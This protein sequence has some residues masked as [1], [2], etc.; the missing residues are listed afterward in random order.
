MATFGIG[1]VARVPGGVVLGRLAD[2]RGR[3]VAMTR[4]IA[5]MGVGTAVVGL[6][7][8]YAVLG[9]YAPLLLLAG[10]LLQGFSAGGEFGP[11]T[12]WLAE[13]APA[14]SRNLHVS[15]QISSQGAAILVAAMCG[16][17][18]SGA[19]AGR[20]GDVG[21]ALAV[22][23]W[24]ADRTRRLDD[25]A[26]AAGDEQ[27]SRR[28]RRGGAGAHA[29]AHVGDLHRLDRGRNGDHASGRAVHAD[30]SD[31]P[32]AVAE[33]DGL[34]VH[35]CVGCRHFGRD[36][37]IA[38]LADRCGWQPR[39]L[40]MATMLIIACGAYPAFRVL[41]SAPG[42][43]VVLVVT[44][45]LSIGLA[46]MASVGF[47]VLCRQF[48]RE[49]RAFGIGTAYNVA[50]CVF[51]GFSQ[52]VVTWLIGAS[53]SLSAPAWYLIGCCTLSLIALMRLPSP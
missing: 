49:Q 31:P 14:Q 42:L 46:A 17:V 12:A 3:K 27:T 9:I 25:P 5:L 8:S 6:T 48:P 10:R 13:V 7:P 41:A 18:L 19:V 2:R 36:A 23:V 28:Q 53:H 35:L 1:F 38:A 47:T 15:W 44:T 39:R 43:G 37:V 50:M 11:T 21:M 4:A 29:V 51:G 40:L 33:H 32:R 20:A 26:L 24:S 22:S 16:L 52:F 34:S 45:L 30:L